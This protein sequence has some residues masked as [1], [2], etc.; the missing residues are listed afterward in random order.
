M[1]GKRTGEHA[2][3]TLY[4]QNLTLTSPTSGG[5]SVGTVRWHNQDTE[6]VCFLT[7][8]RN[9]STYATF[10]HFGLVLEL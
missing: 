4:P 5:R 10:H 9:F 3:V 7:R 6:F 2:G 8:G 1:Q